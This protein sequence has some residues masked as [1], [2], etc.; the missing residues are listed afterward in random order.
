MLQVQIKKI[1]NFRHFAC[2]LKVIGSPPSHQE[3][4]SPTEGVTHE[5]EGGEVQETGQGGA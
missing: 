1:T 2:G 3:H 4:C 5:V